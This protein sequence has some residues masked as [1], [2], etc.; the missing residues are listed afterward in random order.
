[1]IVLSVAGFIG[2]AAGLYEIDRRE[3]STSATAERNFAEIQQRV[4][5][6]AIKSIFLMI[7]SQRS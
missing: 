3:K 1:L 4:Q 5:V 2:L 7:N 6:L